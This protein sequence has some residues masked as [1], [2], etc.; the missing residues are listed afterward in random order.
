MIGGFFN[1]NTKDSNAQPASDPSPAPDLRPLEEVS[2]APEG[3]GFSSPVSRI[4]QQADRQGGYSKALASDRVVDVIATITETSQDVALVYSEEDALLG[5]FTETDYI[6]VCLWWF[7]CL[8]LRSMYIHKLVCPL[9]RNLL[10]FYGSRQ[11]G[12]I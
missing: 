7:Q 9:C 1:K 5:I 11:D 3:Y 6:K 12:I 8:V 10:V 4:L 2:L